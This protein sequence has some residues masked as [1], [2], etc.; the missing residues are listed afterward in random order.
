MNKSISCI[1]MITSFLF[2]MPSPNIESSD[3]GALSMLNPDEVEGVCTSVSLRASQVAGV[4]NEEGNRDV[5]LLVTML[6]E[7]YTRQSRPSVDTHIMSDVADGARRCVEYIND[8]FNK[9]VVKG[10]K[11]VVDYAVEK[12]MSMNGVDKGVVSIDVIQNFLKTFVFYSGKEVFCKDFIYHILSDG[13]VLSF[14]RSGASVVNERVKDIHLF[15]ETYNSVRKMYTDM[16]PSYEKSQMQLEE[17]SKF[18]ESYQELMDAVCAL[19]LEFCDGAR[20]ADLSTL[21]FD[22][23][24]HELNDALCTKKQELSDALCTKKQELSDVEARLAALNDTLDTKKLELSDVGERLVELNNTLSNKTEE[25][26]LYEKSLIGLTKKVDY[27]SSTLRGIEVQIDAFKKLPVAEAIKN[28]LCGAEAMDLRK[29]SRTRL[30][31]IAEQVR[32]KIVA[33]HDNFVR[34]LF[35]SIK[36]PHGETERK[37]VNDIFCGDVSVIRDLIEKDYSIDLCMPNDESSASF[38]DELKKLNT[39]TQKLL[40]EAQKWTKEA[41]VPAQS[42]ETSQEA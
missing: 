1:A 6:P 38:K 20:D 37:N 15:L 34:C 18:K 21:S 19:Y 42:S 27:I 30:A 3:D 17:Y 39:S 40:E 13:G 8:C 32:D 41:N 10:Y 24:M 22:D 9:L 29:M 14:A 23:Y 25:C 5:S 26:D 7:G 28:A 11:E 12:A 2:C 4:G 33:D 36:N 16:L 35:P 31:N